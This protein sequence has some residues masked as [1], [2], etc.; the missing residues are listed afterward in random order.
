MVINWLIGL[1][2]PDTLKEAKV[3]F[4]A[5]V[6]KKTTIP[7]DLRG[8]VYKAMLKLDC[9][10]A[11]NTIMKMY[12]DCDL[13]D[14][15]ERILGSLG[16]TKD[17]EKL[18]EVLRFS[19][20]DEVKQQNSIY[21]IISATNQ[22][23]GRL[24]AWEFVKENFA[25]F[26]Q[27]YSSGFLLPKVMKH[28]LENFVTEAKAKEI[29]EFFRLNPIPGIDRTVQQSVENIRAN[30]LCLERNIDNITSFFQE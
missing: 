14:E 1:E 11:F 27:R 5:H 21:G 26:V 4:E 2:D 23:Q 29:E 9:D 7:A 3:R 12:R 24:L 18:K 10:D 20:S 17:P 28:T 13:N 22:Y 30:A 8:S 19:M 25:V 16:Y 6:A 15:R